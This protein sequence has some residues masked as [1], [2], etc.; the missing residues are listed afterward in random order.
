MRNV[1]SHADRPGRSGRSAGCPGKATKKKYIQLGARMSTPSSVHTDFCLGRF[2]ARY[3]YPNF[4][5]NPLS[6]KS[7]HN[8]NTLQNHSIKRIILNNFMTHKFAEIRPSSRINFVLG[9]NGTGKSSIV[10]AIC[11]CL[12]GE[13]S[14]MDRS[15]DLQGYI[16]HGATMA[17]VTIELQGTG[18]KNITLTRV[19]KKILSS[20]KP[21]VQSTRSFSGPWSR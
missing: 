2:V 9:H 6:L 13:P 1:S 18:N 7:I 4:L 14:D 5:Q 19:L 8:T 17:S 12:G 21:K 15:Q 3:M 11:L 20:V 16:M 10:C